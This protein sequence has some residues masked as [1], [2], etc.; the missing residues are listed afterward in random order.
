MPW[1]S[2]GHGLGF[3]NQTNATAVGDLDNVPG[4]GLRPWAA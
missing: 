1:V 2:M 3:V 4:Q